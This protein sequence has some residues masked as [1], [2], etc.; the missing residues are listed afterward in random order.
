MLSAKTTELNGEIIF[1]DLPKIYTSSSLMTVSLKN[2]VENGLKYNE[3]EK[4]T[5]TIDYKSE[6][7]KHL[8]TIKDN[9]IGIDEKYHDYIFQMFKRLEARSKKGSGLGLGL[10]KKSIEKLDGEIRVESNPGSGS[11]FLLYLP[12]SYQVSETPS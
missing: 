5:V 7:D 4:P 9:G 6:G 3:S 2:L 8:F 11:S 10:V 1:N 12:K